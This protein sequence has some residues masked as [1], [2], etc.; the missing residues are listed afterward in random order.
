MYPVL[1][2]ILICGKIIEFVNSGE[3]ILITANRREKRCT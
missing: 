3:T 2:N 1:W